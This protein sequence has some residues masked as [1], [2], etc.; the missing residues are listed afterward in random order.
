MALTKFS[1]TFRGRPLLEEGA[2]LTIGHNKE[3][4]S[5]NLRVFFLSV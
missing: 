2:Y 5:L 3:I 1:P 4:L